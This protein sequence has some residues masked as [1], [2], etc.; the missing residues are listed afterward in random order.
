MLNPNKFYQR[1][2][3]F[4]D[5]V[6]EIFKVESNYR[7]E[8]SILNLKLSKKIEDSKKSKKQSKFDFFRQSI[9]IKQ[10]FKNLL[11]SRRSSIKSEDDLENEKEENPFTNFLISESL[12][13]LLN[14]YKKK[15]NLISK[16]VSNLGIILYDFSSQ[17]TDIEKQNKD[18]FNLQ[19]NEKE[20]DMYHNI[21]IE[22]KEKYFDKM[23]EIELFF[24]NDEQNLNNSLNNSINSKNSKN[25]N[26]NKDNNIIINE[27]EIEKKK[28]DELIECRKMY[29]KS[30]EDINNC[31]R[32]YISKINEI[33]NEVQ[34]FNIT[35]NNVLYN[36][37]KTYN[38]HLLNLIKEVGSFCLFYEGKQKTIQE[39][40]MEFSN[41]LLFDTKFNMNYQFEE[42]NPKFNDMHNKKHLSVIQKMHKLIG[43]E[44]DKINNYENKDINNKDN[45]VLFI[46]LMDKF[47][48]GEQK[49]NEKEKYLL[50]GLFN[51]T[52]Y[53]NEFLNKLNTI[54]INKKLFYNKEYFDILFDLFNT[55]YS[56][57]SFGDE[58]NHDVVKLLMIL[59]ET[60][61]YKN[62]NNK[63]FLNNVLK[64]PKEIKDDKFWIKY[65]ELEIEKENKKLKNTINNNNKID[66]KAKYE[67]I[68]LLSNIPH[69]RENIIE[70]EKLKYIIG[71]F[72]DK[73]D[74]S[75]DDFNI[76]K[77][78][79]KI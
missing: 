3:L 6:Y 12:K 45:N 24:H 32:I 20:F 76:I 74:F 27:D 26:K 34:E 62:D 64:Q 16:E 37:F 17:K 30:L 22:A 13:E 36:I 25:K 54:R 8:L 39:I 65:I 57:I 59:S 78:Q 56:K 47:L 33:C 50:K 40:N 43:F 71:Y 79:L 5:I 23:N 42:Y 61:Y 35:E 10:G 75:I 1:I 46:I 66:K 19:K 9:P 77:S 63:I 18:S 29:R 53:I 51:Q 15:H 7:T 70:K 21:L 31:Q 4:N 14:F 55:I 48:S 73:Y 72:R 68:V 11:H 44:F 60:F 28:I 38:D 49:L 67:Y 69:L 41:N 2:K 58:K 52:K